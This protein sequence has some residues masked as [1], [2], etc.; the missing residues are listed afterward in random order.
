MHQPV[1]PE[2]DMD[3]VLRDAIHETELT[4]CGQWSDTCPDWP[5]AHKMG[6]ALR[7]MGIV[8]RYA[9]DP[10]GGPALEHI[11]SALIDLL[12]RA[13]KTWGPTGVARVAQKLANT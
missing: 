9:D 1:K 6:D 13:G 12:T 4:G 8:L 5:L 10:I 3:T 2:F 7:S 11:D